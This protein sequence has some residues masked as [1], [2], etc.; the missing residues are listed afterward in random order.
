MVDLTKLDPSMELAW[1]AAAHLGRAP[2]LPGFLQADTLRKANARRA[3]FLMEVENVIEADIAPIRD[4]PIARPVRAGDIR[5]PDEFQRLIE[6]EAPTLAQRCAQNQTL[7]ELTARL[8]PDISDSAMRASV[9]LRL[10]AGYLDV[11]KEIAPTVRGRT[12]DATT[13]AAAMPRI[14]DRAGIDE[15]FRAGV[16]VAPFY[17]RAVLKQPIFKDGIPPGSFVLE[18]WTD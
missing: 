2:A 11:A 7:T 8:L 16:V 14:N 5:T 4:G 12:N 15:I 3:V 1:R 13:R 10:Y 6:S 17:K 9:C 18:D